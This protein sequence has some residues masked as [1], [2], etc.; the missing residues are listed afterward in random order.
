MAPSHSPPSDDEKAYVEPAEYSDGGRRDSALIP[1]PD[2]GKSDEEKA[3]IVRIDH[4]IYRQCSA[5]GCTGQGAP[6][7][8]R[9]QADPM[10][11]CATTTLHALNSRVTGNQLCFLYLISFLDRCVNPHPPCWESDS[12]YTPLTQSRYQDEHWQC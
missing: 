4:C 12:L 7:E 1:D 10:G 2:E 11:M 8:A 6:V 3:K 5:N 9:L